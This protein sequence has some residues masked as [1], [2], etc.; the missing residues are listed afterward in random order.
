MVAYT[1]FGGLWAL[2]VTDYVQ[3][4]MKS[5]AIILM[6][7][8]AFHAS[9]GIRKGL[10]GLP[11]GFSS[12]VNGPYHWLY[13]VGFA[14]VMF[15]S[16]NASWSLAQK[17]Y[18]VP[19]EWD[20]SKAAYLSGALN[21]IGAPLM[22]LPAILG[23]HFLPDLA[24]SGRSADT[25][26]LL[27]MRLLPE[28]MVGIILAAMFSAT[29]AAVSSDFNAI[30][31]VLT[32]DVYHR[33]ICPS[34]SQ[35][36]LLN[37]GRWLTFALG[38]VTTIL[39]LWIVFSHREALFGLMVTV[40][41]L[42][43]APTLLP[44][45]IGLT[46]RRATARGA[47]LGFICGFA[48]GVT[49][50]LI[51]TFWKPA[52][53]IFASPYGFE[54]ASLI[55]NTVMTLLGMAAGSLIWKRKAVEEQNVARFFARLNRPVLGEAAPVTAVPSSSPILAI[56]TL[57]VASLIALAG[58]ISRSHWARLVDGEAAFALSIVA[59]ALYLRPRSQVRKKQVHSR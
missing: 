51:K 10:A 21:F 11:A 18:S 4:L 45:L 53:T 26:V 20:A 56:S 44:L 49:M 47:L 58:G 29:M 1:F 5:M 31:S 35:H 3:F 43:M 50:L 55:T 34:A 12:P 8:L 36:R 52:S 38:A 2:V 27:V 39:S 57:G 16:Y 37:V 6:V 40:F 32:E 25:Y 23:R 9:G 30:A 22:I 14:C 15:V 42:F 54:G 7:P 28:G 48:T 24:A 17:Y 19:S 13:V 41:G 46:V 33:L 59:I